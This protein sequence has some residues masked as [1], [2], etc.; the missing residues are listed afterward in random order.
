M[1]IITVLSIRNNVTYF[2]PPTESPVKSSA[3]PSSFHESFVLQ[4]RNHTVQA[5]VLVNNRNPTTRMQHKGT[6]WRQ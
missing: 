5:T 4:S 1:Y 6:V 3:N 2:T